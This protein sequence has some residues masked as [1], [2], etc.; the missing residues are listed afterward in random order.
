MLLGNKE[1]KPELGKTFWLALTAGSKQGFT[2]EAFGPDDAAT[3]R[4]LE[5]AI[6][7]PAAFENDRPGGAEGLSR[8][9]P[10]GPGARRAVLYAEDDALQNILYVKEGPGTV[11]LRLYNARTGKAE[12]IIHAKVVPGMNRITFENGEFTSGTTDRSS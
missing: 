4:E 7:S 12:P 11:P 3:R 9:T 6:T 8:R 10:Q 5:E 1:F 2:V